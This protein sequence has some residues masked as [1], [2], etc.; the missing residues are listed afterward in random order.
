MNIVQVVHGLPPQERAGTEILTL[1]L[2]RALQARGHQVTIVARTFAPEHEEFSL[3]EEQDEHGLRIIRIVNNYTRMSSFRLHYDNPFFHDIFRRLLDRCRADIVHFQHVVHLSASLIPAVSTLGYPTVLSLHDFFFACHLVQLIDRADQICPGPQGGERCVAC[4]HDLASAEAVRHRFTSM[5]QVLQ[6]PR[7]VITPSAF[8]ARRIA[9]DFPFLHDRLQV[10]APGLPL[11][12][13]SAQDGYAQPDTLDD[14][15][16]TPVTARLPGQPLRIVYVGALLPHKGAHVLIDALKGIPSERVHTSFYGAG[17]ASKQAYID[18]LRQAAAGLSVHWGGV[19]DRSELQAILARHDVLVMP[20]IWEETFSLVTREALQAG[21]PV[22]AARRGALSEV[23]QDGRNGLLFE[24]ENAEDLRRCLRRLLDEPE[25]LAQLKPDQF[26]WRDADVYAQEVERTYEAVLAQSGP[27]PAIPQVPDRPSPSAQASATSRPAALPRLLRDTPPD[28]APPRLSVCL[29]TYNGEAYVAEALR[30]VLQQSYTDFEVVAIDDGS[31]DRTLEILQEF[32]DPRIRIYQNLHR[33]GIPG[34]WNVAVELARGEYVCVF[35]QDDVMRA[36][37]LT[38]KMALFETDP[39]LSLVHS[40]AESVVEAGA[41]S[42][43][44]DGIG[45]A[46]TDFVEE[47]E[48]YFRKLLL[49]G[50]CI[51]APTVMVRCEQLAAVGGFNEALGYACDY[52]MWM[53]LC[54]EGRVGFIHDVLVRYRWHAGNASHDYRDE[55]GMEDERG[56]EECG[57]AIRAAV[58]Y[59]AQRSGDTRQAQLLAEAAEAVLEQRQW[60]AELDRGRGWLE[61][62]RQRWQELGEEREQA[63]HAQQVW[64]SELEQGK[65]WLAEQQATWQAQAEARGQVVEEQ[66]AWIAEL[67]QGKAWL[68]EQQAT[69]QAQAE[70]RGQVVEEQRAWI[71][72]LEQG[73]AWLAEQQATWQAQAEARG[74]VVEEQRAWIAELEQGKAWLAEQQAT[75]QAQAEARGQVVEEQRAWIA[76]LEQGKAWLAEQQ[77]TWQAQA[78]ARGQVVEEQR[79]WIAELEQGKAWLAEQQATWQ[80]QAEARGQVVEEQR[81]WIAELEQGKAWLAEQQ[82]TWQ[83]Q[84]EARGQVVEEQR[85][86]IAELE[87]GKAWL[88]EQQATWQAQAEARGQVVEE[89]RAWIAELE[90]GKAWLAEQQATWQAQA[91]ARGQVVEE[92]RAWIAELEQGKAWLAEQ[93]ATWQAQ[94]EARGQVVEE[95]R[96]WIAELEQGKAWLAEQQATWQAQ[97]EH[98]QAQTHQWQDSLWGRL[99]LLLRIVSPAQAFPAKESKPD[100]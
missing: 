69:W 23:V 9:D 22:I 36:D 14:V 6:F 13:G 61:S 54:V 49:G 75:W 28:L 86:W 33:R 51:C 53:K 50:N 67:E 71:A 78:E 32:A 19:Y 2:S 97:A 79:A 4:L 82:A 12:P 20:V 85:A 10:I 80:A 16:D 60:A 66:R 89:Q 65:A 48:A 31:S 73:K 5:T 84:A 55:R 27:R 24:P 72:E 1:E 56:L 70:A 39:S 57:R 94:A 83:A 58:A 96:A 40:R 35:H 18:Q 90:Q 62:Q 30:S 25:L 17:L 47:G 100:D 68:A 45:K 99:G 87:Q 64:A 34:N 37:N 46:E 8:L 38:R 93:Q 26:V 7:R 11:P 21:L 98:W 42:R 74:Q 95:Q 29:P 52:E 77:A 76:E 88:A 43:L 91:E 92:Q 63:L 44:S 81:A 41:P 3:Q 15:P 59:Y